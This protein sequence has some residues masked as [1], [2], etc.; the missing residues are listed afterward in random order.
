[1]RDT[2]KLCNF[3]NDFRLGFVRFLRK[4]ANA[5]ESHFVT[6]WESGPNFSMKVT[7]ASGAQW[8]SNSDRTLWYLLKPDSME[9]KTAV[10]ELLI[11]LNMP[12]FFISMQH[13]LENRGYID[14]LV[15]IVEV[16]LPLSVKYLERSAE[17]EKAETNKDG[18]LELKEKCT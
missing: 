8:T 4:T 11:Y 5:V 13:M 15:S 9:K 14:S 6:T 7:F 1:M 17:A 16:G 12:R 18:C 10:I 2:L 3:F